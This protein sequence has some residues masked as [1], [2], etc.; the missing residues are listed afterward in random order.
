MIDRDKLLERV[1]G[2][3]LGSDEGGGGQRFGRVTEAQGCS[4]P[5]WSGSR[6]GAGGP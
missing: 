6:D 1:P 5:L 4:R 3:R 2:R